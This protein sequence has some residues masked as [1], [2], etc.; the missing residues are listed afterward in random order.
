MAD[1]IIVKVSL[2]DKG[3]KKGL[4]NIAKVTAKFTQNINKLVNIQKKLDAHQKI[5]S[6]NLK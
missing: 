5:K 2:D 6:I 4:E 1:D 3:L